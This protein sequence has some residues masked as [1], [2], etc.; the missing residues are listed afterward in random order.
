MRVLF[1]IGPMVFGIVCAIT[2]NAAVAQCVE[3]SYLPAP[4]RYQHYYP[5]TGVKPKVGRA[6]DLSAVSN[7]PKPQKNDNE[8]SDARHRRPHPMRPD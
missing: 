8:N 1:A 6:E 5:T 4:P 7:V 3:R 2:M